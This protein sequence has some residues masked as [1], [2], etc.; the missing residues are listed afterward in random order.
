MLGIFSCEL[1]VFLLP[2]NLG[3]YYW[4]INSN[5]F[6]ICYINANIYYHIIIYSIFNDWGFNS[7]PWKLKRNYLY[8]DTC[9]LNQCKIIAYYFHKFSAVFLFFFSFF[10]SAKY[11]NFSKDDKK[12]KFLNQTSWNEE[13]INL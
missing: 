6:K 5:L 4:G 12:L 11:W 2:L 7:K 8:K 10:F 1:S 13:G 9:H 3:L